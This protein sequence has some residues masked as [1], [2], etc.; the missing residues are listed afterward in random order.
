MYYGIHSIAEVSREFKFAISV[1]NR[2]ADT[3]VLY[4]YLSMRVLDA[5][6]EPVKYSRHLGRGGL[7]RSANAL[8]NVKFV[9]LKPGE[10]WSFKDCVAQYMHDSKWINGWRI[11]DTGTYTLEFTYKFD[12]VG[13]KAKCDPKWE[14]LHDANEPWNRT[15]AIE[16]KF[17][18][19]LVVSP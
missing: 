15:M 6:G 11:A 5:K 3:M 17:S 4:P 14:R 1:K 7:R 19:Q 2:G 16:H 10:S 18:Q 8:E 13:E 12:R 9:T